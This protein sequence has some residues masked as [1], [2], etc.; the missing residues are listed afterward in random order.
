[1]RRSLYRFMQA[2]KR[3][4]ESVPEKPTLSKSWAISSTK[5]AG[6]SFAWDES[7]Q[8]AGVVCAAPAS[9]LLR[10]QEEERRRISREIHD[11]LSQK[12][13]LLEIE[14]E[15]LEGE[16]SGLPKI[17]AQ[18]EEL[19]TSVCDVCTELHRICHALHPAVLEDLGLIPALEGY[20]AEYTR[21]TGVKTMLTY[22]DV[23]RDIPPATA[24]CVYRIVQ[25]ALRNTAKHSGAKRAFVGL[26][27]EAGFLHV[28]I[29][30]TGCGF[31]PA[32]LGHR[33]GIGLVSLDERA[34]LA[35]GKCVLRSAPGRGTRIRVTL[36]LR[37]SETIFFRSL[38]PEAA[39][40][41]AAGS[42]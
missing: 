41:A 9:T 17:K 16:L 29:R 5:A 2:R 19:R 32:A 15:T 4:Q 24:L 12:L 18:I 38:T 22:S 13:A 23:P 28:A 20:C 34:R 39:K 25:E 7:D 35:G 3:M 1:M 27:S 42:S 6:N 10:V 26:R 14:L 21:W 30:D 33:S 11:G 40:A 37:P 36:P 31:D 8:I